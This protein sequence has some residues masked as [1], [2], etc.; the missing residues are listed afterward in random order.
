[1]HGFIDF[2]MG[3]Y[4]FTFSIRRINPVCYKMAFAVL[5]ISSSNIVV[6]MLIGEFSDIAKRKSDGARN[7]K[8]LKE[9][10]KGK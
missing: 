1:M 2:L 6:T 9:K 8:Y 4:I 10:T 5:I 3:K 7:R